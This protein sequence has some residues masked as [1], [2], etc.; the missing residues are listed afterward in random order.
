MFGKK[1]KIKRYLTEKTQE[2]Y[3]QFYYVLDDFINKQLKKKLRDI[4]LSR[5]EIHVDGTQDLS[6]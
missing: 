6:V 2:L 5:I 4:G 3:S 1:R